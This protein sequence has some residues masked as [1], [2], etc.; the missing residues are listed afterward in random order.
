MINEIDTL[1]KFQ[2]IV[3]DPFYST[4]HNCMVR[5]DDNADMYADGKLHFKGLSEGMIHVLFMEWA[6][7]QKHLDN[8]LEM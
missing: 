7:Y 5:V 1:K 6:K 8:L 3:E 4:I 2:Y